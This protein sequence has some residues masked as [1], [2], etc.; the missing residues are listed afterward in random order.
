MQEKYENLANTIIKQAAKDLRSALK[1]LSRNPHDKAAKG[2]VFEIKSFF[3]SQYYEVLS[4]T[5]GRVLFSMIVEEYA[6]D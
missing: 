5:N 3:F 4:K 6:N 2:T 1:A